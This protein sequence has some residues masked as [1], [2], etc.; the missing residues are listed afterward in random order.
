MCHKDDISLIIASERNEA[1]TSGRVFGRRGRNCGRRLVRPGAV[2]AACQ[3]HAHP[4]RRDVC[5]QQRV[6]RR[7]RGTRALL[8]RLRPGRSV[9]TR[10]A[11]EGQRQRLAVA[12][13]VTRFTARRTTRC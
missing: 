5:V 4:V 6:P 13:P 12:V 2:A 10:R 11:T 1:D 9:R 7:R 3:R 8:R